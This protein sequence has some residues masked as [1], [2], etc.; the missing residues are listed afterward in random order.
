MPDTAVGWLRLV[1]LVEGSSFLLLLAVM[2]LK[3]LADTPGPVRVVGTAHGGLWV[4]YLLVA[5][6]A[7]LKRRWGVGRVA[8]VLAASV[9]PGGPFLLDASLRREDARG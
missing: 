8:A 1:G 6:L 4:L 7:A 5:T 9:L 2:P 3:Y